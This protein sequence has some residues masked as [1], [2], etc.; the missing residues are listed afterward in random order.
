MKSEKLKMLLVE[1]QRV[2]YQK[3]GAEY[4]VSGMNDSPLKR[5]TILYCELLERQQNEIVFEIV[6]NFGEN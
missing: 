5:A 3:G 2:S 4:I 1:L 6:S